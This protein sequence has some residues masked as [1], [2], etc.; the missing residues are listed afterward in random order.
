MSIEIECL[1]PGPDR[2]GESPLWDPRERVLWWVD[3]PAPALQ[4]QTVSR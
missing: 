3:V 2:F 4:R 1:H